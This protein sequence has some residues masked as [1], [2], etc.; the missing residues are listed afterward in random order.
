VSTPDNTD[1][2]PAELRDRL[3]KLNVD[4]DVRA[5]LAELLSGPLRLPPDVIDL[6][7]TNNTGD[8]DSDGLVADEGVLDAIAAAER[9]EDERR[10]ACDAK[11]DEMASFARWLAI[12]HDDAE[13]DH[14][15][16]AAVSS[17]PAHR[18][19]RYMLPPDPPPPL[20]PQCKHPRCAVAFD[21][22]AARNLSAEEV[23]R[24]WPR[25]HGTCPD[26]GAGLIK[27]ASFMHYA[28]GD[29]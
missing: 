29:W 20:F 25:F 12:Q 14:R 27:Y 28:M 9:E 7:A 18:S 4:P 3:A 22:D 15:G 5:R 1:D 19:P 21:E 16:A 23:Q 2:L 24:R 11:E 13:R 6:Y 8:P 10:W 17:A 26:C